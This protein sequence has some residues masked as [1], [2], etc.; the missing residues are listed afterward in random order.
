MAE[1]NPISKARL[2]EL[3]R[4]FEQEN[5]RFP[6]R[7]N[8]RELPESAEYAVI[9]YFGTLENAKISYF[10][11]SGNTESTNPGFSTTLVVPDAHVGPGQDL[12]RFDALSKLINHKRPTRIIF[13]G[14][15]V[16]LEALSNWDLQK[17]GIMEG[18]RYWEDVAAGREALRRSLKLPFGYEPEVVYI[19][20]NHETRLERYV[21]TK[22]ELTGMLDLVKDLQLAEVGITQV[23]EYRDS[24]EFDGVIFTHAPQNAAN[25]AVSGKY[26]IH[27]AAE[28]SAK[29]TVFVHTHRNEGVN[30]YRHGAGDITQLKMAGAFFEHT[31]DYAYGGLNSYWRGLMLLT[32]WKDGRFDVEEI[33]LERLKLLYPEQQF[34]PE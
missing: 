30:Y 3:I 16:T 26:A 21:E 29:S 19:K 5:G 14:D 22:P 7:K 31:D 24:I 8:I 12:S 4:A 11:A 10:L 1:H 33:S 18:K 6:F 28:M 17:A 32:H 15:F 34:T 2:F 25:Q 20:G 27:R 23:V 13:M 9:K